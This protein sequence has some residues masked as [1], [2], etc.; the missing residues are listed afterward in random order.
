MHFCSANAV[1]A[2]QN[3]IAKE[4]SL[5]PLVYMPTIVSRKAAC[6]YCLES[7]MMYSRPPLIRPP[8]QQALGWPYTAGGFWVGGTSFFRPYIEPDYPIMHVLFCIKLSS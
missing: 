2:G 8:L 5:L 7:V 6:S 4:N 3:I 1:L